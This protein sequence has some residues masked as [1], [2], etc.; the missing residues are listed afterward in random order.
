LGG[1]LVKVYPFTL[2]ESDIERAFVVIRKERV[3]PK[4]YPRKAG[5]PSKEPLH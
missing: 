5:T 4:K 3:C 2:P 1:E